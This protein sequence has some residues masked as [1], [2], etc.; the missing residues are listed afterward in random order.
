M[1]QDITSVMP[2]GKTP[3]KTFFYDV[4]EV[5]GVKTPFKIHS[6][7]PQVKIILTFTEIKNNVAVENSKFAKPKE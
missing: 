6:I 7:T 3:V 4:R 1:R 2:E 5:D